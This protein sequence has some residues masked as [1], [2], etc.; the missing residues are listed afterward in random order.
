MAGR[1]TLPTDAD[2]RYRKI[3]SMKSNK[4][5]RAEIKQKR[6]V[7]A[8][9]LKR[10]LQN[11]VPPHHMDLTGAVRA[12]AT[13]L[14]HNDTRGDLPDYYFDKSFT[15]VDCESA[16]VWTAKQQK[17]WYEIAKGNIASTAIRC[18]PCRKRKRAIKSEARRVSLEGLAK[19]TSAMRKPD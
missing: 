4:Q 2:N 7:R 6:L 13:E 5:R 18:R 14:R 19:K 12:N 1:N 17:W 10:E 15:C 9:K 8:E 3:Y 11:T 16:E